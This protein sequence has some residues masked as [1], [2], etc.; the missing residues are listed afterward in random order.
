MVHIR[1]LTPSCPT[2][3]VVFRA[4]S[5]SKDPESLF[6]TDASPPAVVSNCRHPDRYGVN[7]LVKT[8]MWFLVFS[9]FFPVID[10]CVCSVEKSPSNPGTISSELA[11]FPLCSG[12]AGLRTFGA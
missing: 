7:V 3:A 5:S 9:L 12:A 2:A 6:L 1:T 8:V 10:D 4:P 11:G